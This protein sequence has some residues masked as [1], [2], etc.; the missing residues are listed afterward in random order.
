MEDKLSGS[1]SRGAL[2]LESEDSTNIQNPHAIPLTHS[3]GV[4][5]TLHMHADTPH[6]CMC[7]CYSMSRTRA[8]LASPLLIFHLLEQLVPVRLKVLEQLCMDMQR[9]TFTWQHRVRAVGTGQ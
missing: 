9:W 3:M 8:Y 4:I 6:C 2:G 5:H 7:P 1:H